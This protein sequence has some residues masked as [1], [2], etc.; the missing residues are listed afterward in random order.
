MPPRPRSLDL[1]SAIDPEKPRDG[2]PS[3]VRRSAGTEIAS[4]T[5]CRSLAGRLRCARH[6]RDLGLRLGRL[7]A[8]SDARREIS[9]ARLVDVE[10]IAAADEPCRLFGGERQAGDRGIIE[11]KVV[12]H[13]PEYTSAMATA[14]RFLGSRCIS[15]A[16]F[17]LLGCS[18]GSLS[19]SA[20]PSDRS[21]GVVIAQVV[22]HDAR[23]AILGGSK[24]VRVAVRR[25]DGTL[26]A[27]GLTLAELRVQ[28]PEIYVVVTSAFASADGQS[29]YVDATLGQTN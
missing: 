12:G 23:I 13:G 14:A 18:Q 6:Q 24:E 10:R 5:I 9:R 4:L 21:P 1:S 2:R 7:G 15:L 3:A 17:I 11:G 26:V 8:L 27:D 22:T 25:L 19:T 29:T 16:A 28:Q 20:P